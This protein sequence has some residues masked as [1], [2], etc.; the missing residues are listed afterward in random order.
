MFAVVNHFGALAGGHYTS[1]VRSA[2][3]VRVCL[4]VCVCVCV[5]VCVYVWV[6]VS[7]WVWVWVCMF[8][9]LYVCVSVCACDLD[10]LLSGAGTWYAVDDRHVSP[11]VRAAGDANLDEAVERAINTSAAY[12]LFYRKRT[13]AAVPAVALRRSERLLVA[14]SAKGAFSPPPPPVGRKSTGGGPTQCAQCGKRTTLKC[15]ACKSVYF[16][17]TAC[18][19]VA[20]EAHKKECGG[21]AKA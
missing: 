1:S 10:A 6:W 9:C 19:K 13:M 21:G 12:L 5:C 4:F 15:S 8:V 7:V 11:L 2:S 20:W 14:N 3:G 17:S 16:C 18:Q